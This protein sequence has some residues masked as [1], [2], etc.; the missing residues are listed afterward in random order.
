M[1]STSIKRAV[2]RVLFYLLRYHE[3]LSGEID[4]DKIICYRNY[5]FIFLKLLS[6]FPLKT[7]CA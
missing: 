3:P 7:L 6:F 2:S 1:N 4:E 5:L